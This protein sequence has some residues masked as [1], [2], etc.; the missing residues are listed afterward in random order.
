MLT[1]TS[2]LE[3]YDKM[4]Y[5]IYQRPLSY[6]QVKRIN[7]LVHRS[8]DNGR[9][10]IAF[11]FS[12]FA[13]AYFAL[14]CPNEE[15]ANQRA[16]DAIKLDVYKQTMLISSNDGMSLSLSEIF[17]A[18]NGHGTEEINVVSLKEHPCVSVGDIVV[19]LTNNITYMCMP[20]GWK[21][22][23]LKLTLA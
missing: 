22:L 11:S 18:G 9:E 16:L 4:T 2:D 20:V 15:N 8:K 23:D 1:Y 14:M 7:A 3:G 21:E 13:L 19:D 10:M 6:A 12:E 5:M 17:D